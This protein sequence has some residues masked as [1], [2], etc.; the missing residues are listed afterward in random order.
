MA[1]SKR[2]GYLLRPRAFS[3][4]AFTCRDAQFAV[5]NSGMSG[6]HSASDTRDRDMERMWLTERD[7]GP[8]N[9]IGFD[10]GAVIRLGQMHVWN[11]N[12][13][14]AYLAGVRKAEILYSCDGENYSV[15]KGKGYPYEF[16][17]ADGSEALSATDLICGGNIDFSGLSVRFVK[18]VPDTRQGEG[19]WGGYKEEQNRFGLS[20][21]RFYA[22]NPDIREK[23]FLYPYAYRAGD[24]SGL[25][26][27]TSAFGLN[28]VDDPAAFHGNA[29]ETMWLSE[30]N[31][32]DKRIVFDFGG[33]YCL[34]NAY[35][36]NYNASGMTGAGLKNVKV[37]H[38]LDGHAWTELNGGEPL[39][40][41]RAAG[42][43]DMPP[44][45]LDDGNPLDFKGVFCRYVAFEPCGGAGI[46][47][48]GFCN[49]YEFRIGLS[50][51]IFSTTETGVLCEPAYDWTGIFSSYEG[52]GGGDGI[53][54]VALDGRDCKRATGQ[55]E[56]RSLFVFGDT[57]IGAVN[58]VTRHRRRGDFVNNT[59]A[60]MLGTEPKKDAL[61]FVSGKTDGDVPAS[62]IKKQKD[63]TYWLQDCAV[64]GGR[65]YSFA[66]VILPYPE[67]PEGFQFR[68]A[69]I[70]QI[71]FPIKDGMIDYAGQRISDTPFYSDMREQVY[72]GAGILVNTEE[73]GMPFPDGYVYVYGILGGAKKRL[74]VCR[75]RPADIENFSAYRFFDGTGFSERI[76]DS[77]PVADNLSSEMSVTPIESGAYCGK[78]LYVYCDNGVGE[79]VCAAVGETPYG[80]FAEPVRLYYMHDD[81]ELDPELGI[82]TYRYNAKAHYHL[83]GDRELLIS[84]N[85][86]T[87]DYESHF[88]NA[89]IYRPRFLRLVSY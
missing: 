49:G 17:C 11:F 79:M 46:G 54:S 21:V 57:F 69:G 56:V 4:V 29:A 28:S 62:I 71:S 8:E 76:E 70:D 45:N 15:Y 13:S 59:F 44:S 16:R 43:P 35:I 66:D 47:T 19:N 85:V 36:W 51:V 23:R 86:N 80:P 37:A 63:C 61:R 48:W 10:F 40:F 77:A 5:D 3:A 1:T 82:K 89:D 12:Q 84:Y 30:N 87:T 64:I 34:S 18:I 25:S 22:Y 2:Y 7:P 42:N 39:M 38:S 88:K 9:W 60:Y 6:A 27:L 81:R 75:V 24:K 73:A 78:Y 74:T 53:F 68:L 83:S 67:G 31:P 33:S 55:P 65:L 14:D 50:K 20:A 72:Y 32:A 41:G 26:V 58:P 52:W